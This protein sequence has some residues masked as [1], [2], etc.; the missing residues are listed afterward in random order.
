[1]SGLGYSKIQYDLDALRALNDKIGLT[2]DNL[3]SLDRE[4]VEGL[5]KL[6]KDWYTPNGMK[7]F[8]ELDEGWKIEVQQYIKTLR[9]FQALLLG[10]VNQYEEIN[11]QAEKISI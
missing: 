7:F 8:S 10:T 2:I 6:R 5:E 1:M 3:A 9:V 11:M 4:L